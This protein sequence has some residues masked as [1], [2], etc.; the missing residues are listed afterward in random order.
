MQRLRQLLLLSLLAGC[1][2]AEPERRTPRAEPSAS[3]VAHDE[4]ARQAHEATELAEADVEAHETL[5]LPPVVR[6][7]LEAERAIDTVVD[8][9]LARGD[10]P[11]VVVLVGRRDGVIFRRA[12][13]RRVVEPIEKPMTE[14]T[15]F[16]L[17]SLT[18]PFTALTAMRVA[19]SRGVSL[20]AT[21]DAVLPELAGGGLTLRDLMTHR[22]GL[23]RVNALTDYEGTREERIRR[24]LGGARERARGTP[25]YGDLHFLALG[26]W[27]ERVEGARLDEVMRREVLAP[28]QLDASFGP[29]RESPTLRLAATER[30]PRR[31]A[32]GEPAPILH[33]DVDD[34]R[35]WRLDHVA[36]HA[37]LFASADDLAKLAEALLHERHWPANLHAAMRRCEGGRT[38]GWDCD[39]LARDGFSSAA[40]AH[41]GY[42]GTWLAIDPTN[43]LYVVVLSNRVHPDG[44]GRVGDLR[45]AVARLALEARAQIP[46]PHPATVLGVDRLRAEFE[47]GASRLAGRR[48]A[49]LTHDAGRARDGLPTS[50]LFWRA[51]LEGTLSLA[52][53]FAPEH[54]LASDAEGHVENGTF[55]GVPVTS[56]F[57]RTRTPSAED[58]EGVDVIVVDVQDVGARFFTY[59][60]TVHEVLRAAA[61]HH[62]EVLVLDRPNPLGAVQAGPVLDDR[63]RSFVNHHPLPLRHGQTIGELARRLARDDGLDLRLD[64]LAMDEVPADWWASGLRWVPPSPNLPTAKS[65]WLYLGVA[66]VEGTNVSVGRGTDLPFEVVGAPWV[67]ADALLA[68]MGTVQ[69]V[70]VEPVHFTPEARPYRRERC[71]GLRFELVDASRFDPLA[72]GEAL[73]RALARTHPDAWDRSRLVRMIGDDATTERWT[74]ATE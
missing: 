54:G 1:G 51:H 35:A 57:G 70:H 15:R 39:T 24:T 4:A 23:R 18:K 7:P 71:H 25:R 12:Y 32:E 20:D 3:H 73:V 29:L 14:D 13:G 62:V 27:I 30:A 47:A 44:E 21:V 42:T 26:T 19:E 65:A 22:A 64:V 63:Y 43:D 53:I 16:D 72:L 17:A 48:V 8:R 11:G 37:G 56:L 52:R 58:L 69:G 41:G 46:P 5:A 2:S 38:L 9:A 36:G 45:S 60:S 49:L 10:V 68:S 55:R 6:L 31:A 28:L 40:F 66:L 74:S 67:D 50:E 33:G 61:T 34:P 59:A